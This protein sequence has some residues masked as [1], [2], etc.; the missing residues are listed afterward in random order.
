MGSVVRSSVSVWAGVRR[1]RW[2]RARV[3]VREM[4]VEPG[5]GGGGAIVVVKSLIGKTGDFRLMTER[6]MSWRLK[7]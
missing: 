2:E 1:V 7:Y 4:G 3:R 5:G 6:E